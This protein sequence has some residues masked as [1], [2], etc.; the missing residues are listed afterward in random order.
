MLYSAIRSMDVKSHSM[1]QGNI[2]V[3]PLW[4]E[5]FKFFLNGAFWCTLYL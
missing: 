2:L 1:A 3:G 4:K 5:N